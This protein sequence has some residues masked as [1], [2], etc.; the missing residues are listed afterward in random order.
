MLSKNAQ[1]VA[2]DAGFKATKGSTK[3]FTILAANAKKLGITVSELQ[4][5]GQ[6]LVTAGVAE[7]CPSGSIRKV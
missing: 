5:A 3:E 1:K 7:N 4:A 6:E 2:D